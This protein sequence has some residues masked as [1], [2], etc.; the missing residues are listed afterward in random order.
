MGGKIFKKYY[1]I[2]KC[3]LQQ[4]NKLATE[5]KKK[6]VETDVHNNIILTLNKKILDIQLMKLNNSL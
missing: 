4:A 1:D 2:N 5:L 6:L 3:T